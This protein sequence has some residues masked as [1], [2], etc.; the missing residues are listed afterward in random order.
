MRKLLYLI[1][2]CAV[3]GSMCAIQREHKML[4][5]IV[6]NYEKTDSPYQYYGYYKEVFRKYNY[7]YHDSSLHFETLDEN[8][9]INIFINEY[10]DTVSMTYV[11]YTN[12]PRRE[13]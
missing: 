1:I 5:E 8:H 10:G 2:V 3:V 4:K 9:G 13:E 12:Y 11:D 6:V 7:L